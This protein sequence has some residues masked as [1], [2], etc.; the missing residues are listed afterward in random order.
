MSAWVVPVLL[1]GGSG[2]RLWPLSRP[3]RPK[4]VLSLTT[5]RT[6][7]AETLHRLD[8][9]ALGTTLAITGA[10][11]ADLVAADL[12]PDAR[13]MIEPEGRGTAAAIA[14][15]ALEVQATDPVL[16]VLPTDHHVADPVAWRAA[17]D[18]AIHAASQ[19]EVVLLG[20]KPTRPETGY[21]W[22]HAP[23][24]PTP[25]LPAL[26]FVEKPPLD[27][28]RALLADGSWWWNAGVFVVRAKVA[29]ALLAR[30][31]PDVLDAAKLAHAELERGP[32]LRLGE[33]FRAIPNIPFDR[34]VMERTTAARCVPVDAGWTDL[35]SFDALW[36]TTEHDSADNT[37]RG[38]V[39]LHDAHGCYVHATH[40]RV[41]VVGAQD[42]VVIE[43]PDEVLVVPRARAQEVRDAVARLGELKCR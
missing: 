26:H 18:V 15:A 33:R 42:L 41:V 43:T 5:E 40:R 24:G 31:A 25:A 23:N 3:D 16:V 28:A 13:V 11:T 32:T 7:F 37:A 22:I 20:V 30:H 1:C 12:P 8:G 29:L 6:L 21:G 38:D 39:L 36:Q 10:A 4:Q 14:L 19:D 27:V 17:L 9:F 34:A 2:T 35:G